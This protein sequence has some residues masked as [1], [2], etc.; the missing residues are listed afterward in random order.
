MVWKN[1]AYACLSL[2]LHIWIMA[3][4]LPGGPEGGKQEAEDAVKAE[5]ALANMQKWICYAPLQQDGTEIPCC[6]KK[7]DGDDGN[8]LTELFFIRNAWT[9]ATLHQSN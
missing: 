1:A 7:K 2:S 6:I 9:P 8:P 3:V 5:M 4:S